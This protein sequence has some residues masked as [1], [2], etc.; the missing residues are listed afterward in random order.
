VFDLVDL[1]NQRSVGGCT[2]HIAHPGGLNYTTFPVN[3]SEAESRRLSR[4]F[5]FGHSIGAMPVPPEEHNRHFPTT[6]DLRLTN[7]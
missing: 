7:G 5:P 6:L 1:W 3:A 4:F 2:Y